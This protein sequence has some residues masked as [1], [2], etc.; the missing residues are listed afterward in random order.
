MRCIVPFAGPV[1][2]EVINAL[3]ATGWDWDPQDVSES[4]R[5][6]YD[7]LS[8]A[9]DGAEGFAIVE[10]DIVVRSDTLDE[11]AN[12]P[13]DWCAFAYQYGH[14]GLQYGLGCVKFSTDLIARCPD[15]MD[16][17]GVLSDERHPR[18]HWCRLDAWLQGVVLPSMGE[19]PHG[20]GPPLVHLNHGVAHG[21]TS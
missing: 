9:W 5:A 2:R 8:D 4:D 21:C 7:L 13:H 10:H 17:V 3:D 15:A 20:H 16:R 6:Y 1:R 11:L 18:R 19:T 14:W 12:C